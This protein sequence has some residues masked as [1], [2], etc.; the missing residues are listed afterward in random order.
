MK[1]VYPQ[2]VVVPSECT[3][4]FSS[5]FV[6]D[7]M[8]KNAQNVI[9][10]VISVSNNFGF[11]WGLAFMNDFENLNTTFDTLRFAHMRRRKAVGSLERALYR[12]RT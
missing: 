10:F 8:I 7:G 4:N 5:K 12:F 2:N 3:S 6:M 1:W 9:R 11:S